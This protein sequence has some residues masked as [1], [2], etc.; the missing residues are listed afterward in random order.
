VPV[1]ACPHCGTRLDAPDD[2]LGQQ[3]VCGRCGRAFAAE[4]LPPVPGPAALGQA[5]PSAGQEP[6]PPPVPPPSAAGAAGGPPGFAQ[7]VGSYPQPLKSSGYA[8]ASLVLGIA[9][10]PTCFCLGLPSI[11]C[12]ILAVVF[13]KNAMQDIEAGVVSASSAGMAK[14]GRIC[15]MIGIVLGIGYWVVH[16]GMIVARTAL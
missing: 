5:P 2:V 8:V 6:A 4:R 9:S 1:I 12:G 13:H 15:G 16:I 3:V 10:I 11:V 7:P 14:G